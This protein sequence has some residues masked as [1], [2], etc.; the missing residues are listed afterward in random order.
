MAAVH[1]ICKM[2]NSKQTYIGFIKKKKQ[3]YLHLHA[4]SSAWHQLNV[5]DLSSD[6]FIVLVICL[7]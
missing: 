5:G 4:F 3:S 2:E 7:K 1:C 6:W